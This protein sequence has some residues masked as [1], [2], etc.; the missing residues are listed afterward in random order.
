MWF[1]KVLLPTFGFP[2]NATKPERNAILIPLAE[3][4]V[5]AIVETRPVRILVA[6]HCGFLAAA[7]RA[8]AGSPSSAPPT[9]AANLLAFAVGLFV[10]SELLRSQEPLVGNL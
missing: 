8:V 4:D 10:R 9:P 6:S 3:Y 7:L 2:I 5:H 1:S